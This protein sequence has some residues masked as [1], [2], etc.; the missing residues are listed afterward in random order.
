MRRSHAGWRGCGLRKGTP[1]HSYMMS[2]VLFA[3][4]RRSEGAQMHVYECA[5]SGCRLGLGRYALERMINCRSAADPSE[6]TLPSL[7][8]LELALDLKVDSGPGRSKVPGPIRSDRRETERAA[9]DPHSRLAVP[10]CAVW[11]RQAQD[12]WSVPTRR[13]STRSLARSSP[14]PPPLHR[15]APLCAAA[16]LASPF[17]PCPSALVRRPIGTS[18][19]MNTSRSYSLPFR[20]AVN[21]PTHARCAAACAQ[22]TTCTQR[23]GVIC[24]A[25]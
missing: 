16:P 19:R 13:A 14:S 1:F 17:P 9:T 22:G 6:P 12:T 18:D 8:N 3:H 11:P 7:A 2:A 25:A 23:G 15:R 20:D 5:L 24:A 4:D 10:K 21:Y